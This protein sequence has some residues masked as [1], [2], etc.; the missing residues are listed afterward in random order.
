MT[1]KKK[2]EM[3]IVGIKFDSRLQ[4]TQQV[5]NATNKAEKVELNIAP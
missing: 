1:A 2:I 5:A 4:W 3:N